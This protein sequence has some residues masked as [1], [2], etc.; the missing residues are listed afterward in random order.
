MNFPQ[1]FINE[2]C[3]RVDLIQLIGRRVQLTRDGREHAGS[4]PFHEDSTASFYVV[5]GKGFFHCFGCGAHGSAID[6]LMRADK[7][8]FADA[9]QR[10]ADE[11]GLAIPD[12]DPG[13]GCSGGF[14]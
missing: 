2:L 11:A 6:Y 5:A 4:C 9:V 1:T 12:H 14:V 10:L 7:L 13:E 8:D 3:S